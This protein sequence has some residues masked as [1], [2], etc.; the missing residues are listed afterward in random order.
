MDDKKVLIP[1]EE[2]NSLLEDKEAYRK[3]AEELKKD[4][5]ERGLYVDIT[6]DLYAYD[7]FIRNYEEAGFEPRFRVIS[8]DAALN[9]ANEEIERLSKLLKEKADYAKLMEDKVR[10]MSTRNVWQRLTGTYVQKQ[11]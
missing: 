8:N 2:Y 1:L 6:L 3:I 9:L 11:D 5:K 7:S 10:L 4:C